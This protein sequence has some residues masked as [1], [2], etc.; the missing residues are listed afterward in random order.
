MII[1]NSGHG[2][3]SYVFKALLLSPF[4]HQLGS[5]YVATPSN[6]EL[7][8]LKELIESGKIIPVIDRTYPLNDTP[9]AFRYLEESHARGKVVIT[10]VH[11]DSSHS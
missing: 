11:A 4:T 3:M 6:K 1:P 9:N 2:G 5:M 7:V 8:V 10:V